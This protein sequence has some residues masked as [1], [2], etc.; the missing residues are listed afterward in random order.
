MLNDDKKTN[1][2]YHCQLT[3]LGVNTE[4]KSE[5]ILKGHL[6]SLSLNDYCFALSHRRLVSNLIHKNQSQA[7]IS[8]EN[9]HE[10]RQRC[11]TN[12]TLFRLFRKY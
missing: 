5:G 10:L 4:A 9:Q 6:R 1:Q 3:D 7:D 12:N 11:E 8:D 2:T